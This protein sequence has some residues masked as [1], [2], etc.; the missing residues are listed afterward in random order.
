MVR[1]YSGVEEAD[2]YDALVEALR[3]QTSDPEHIG[4]WQEKRHFC[5]DLF[6]RVDGGSVDRLVAD[7]SGLVREARTGRVARGD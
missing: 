6:L 5:R 1:H 3:R 4:V 2:S 7:V